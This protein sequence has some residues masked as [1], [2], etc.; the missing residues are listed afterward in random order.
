[1]IQSFFITLLSI[2]ILIAM[3]SLAMDP[4]ADISPPRKSI[5]QNA[6]QTTRQD[7]PALWAALTHRKPTVIPKPSA[8][9]KAAILNAIEFLD[10]IRRDSGDYKSY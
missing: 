2:I 8:D 3:P 4:D 6:E 5:M 9:D 1:M 10:A 7:N